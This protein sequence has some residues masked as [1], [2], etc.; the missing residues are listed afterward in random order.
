MREINDGHDSD[1]KEGTEYPERWLT[2]FRFDSPL[3]ARY[4]LCRASVAQR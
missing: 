1:D 3:V 2:F 4:T